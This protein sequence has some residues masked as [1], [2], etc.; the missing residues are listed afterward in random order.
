MAYIV[1]HAEKQSKLL[2]MPHHIDRIG[3]YQKDGSV[4]VYPDDYVNEKLRGKSKHPQIKYPE[5]HKWN[6]GGGATYGEFNN[7][8]REE[9]VK[10]ERSP[11]KNASQNASLTICFNNSAGE[12]F[13]EE[14]RKA[15][16]KDEDYYSKCEEF[17]YDCR[18]VLDE[19]Y[20]HG[21][22]LKWT[23]HYEEK[24]PHMHCIKIPILKAPK[25]LS[26][27]D[28]DKNKKTGE[29]ILKFSSGE[30]LGGPDGLVKLQDAIYD[31]IGKKWGLERGVRGSE[32]RHTDLLEWQRE[33]SLKDKK[34]TE[35]L[36]IINEL[37]DK[38]IKDS[39]RIAAQEAEIRNMVSEAEAEKERL[40]KEGQEEA[41]R[42]KSEGAAEK[43]RLIKE[44]NDIKAAAFE[45][46]NIITNDA[47]KYSN[48][49]R[50]KL[51]QDQKDIIAVINSDLTKTIVPQPKKDEPSMKFYE[52]IKIWLKAIVYKTAN[53]EKELNDRE[54]ELNKQ[55]I[56]VEDQLKVLA[57]DFGDKN[58]LILAIKLLQDKLKKL[59]KSKVEKQ[60]KDQDN[61][62]NKQ[63]SRK[64]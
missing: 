2:S 63:S 64:P 5:R 54:L 40:I 59:Q 27:K 32:A 52:R 45:T 31:K 57:G 42:S 61:K 23:T 19:L 25:R 10:L 7:S 47:E 29:A 33:L 13:W 58:K 9:I 44:G 22:T 35:R 46:G 4:R 41:E 16:P 28:K 30:F 14:L 24:E 62:K 43:V 55:K 60:I 1:C 39:E 50:M 21:K 18:V 12:E 26:K 15:Y 48:E 49:K 3:V 53:K 34:L 17:F 37:R 36:K 11:Q 6:R 51:N 20:P 38:N 8:W 56:A